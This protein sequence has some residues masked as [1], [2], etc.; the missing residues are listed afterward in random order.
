M[1]ACAYAAEVITFDGVVVV[2]KAIGDLNFF[3]SADQEENE[4]IVLTVLQAFYE[5]VNMLLRCAF[6]FS[7][8]RS[9]RLRAS[10][11]VSR[12]ACAMRMSSARWSDCVPFLLA[13]RSDRRE[14]IARDF[15]TSIRAR[16]SNSV[17][18]FS[19]AFGP[20]QVLRVLPT[21]L[22][23]CFTTC[24]PPPQRTRTNVDKKNVLENLDLVFMTIDELV[25][26]GC[27][28]R[29]GESLLVLPQAYSQHCCATQACGRARAV[30]IDT[31][32][33]RRAVPESQVWLTRYPPRAAGSSWRSTRQ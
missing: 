23:T 17:W 11:L 16:F 30:V 13:E 20:A 32:P 25:D 28:S 21:L 8:A 6:A 1:S 29:G 33:L 4:L 19:A 26:G 9:S 22:K 15:W 5:A 3:V 18:L 27:A 7:V 24:P 12:D 14:C 10:E 2:Y 31:I